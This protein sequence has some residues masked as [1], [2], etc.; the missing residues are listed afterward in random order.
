MSVKLRW[1]G[2]GCFEIVL[3]SGRVLVTNPYLGFTAPINIQELTG[4]DYITVNHDSWADFADL[5]ALVQKFQS[6]IICGCEV[7]RA[8]TSELFAKQF[9]Q[10]EQRNVIKVTAGEK[11]AFDDL[12]LEVK[13]AVH[14]GLE[15][16]KIVYEIVTGRKPDPGM[17]LAE[18]GKMLPHPARTPAILEKKAQIQAE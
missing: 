13:K 1:L 16:P 11:I 6:T 2:H 4:A 12:S 7:G 9:C 3:P 10:I 8:F 14:H 18:I 15:G 17:P 5:P